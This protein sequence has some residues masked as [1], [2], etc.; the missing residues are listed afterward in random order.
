[1]VSKEDRMR[2]LAFAKYLIEMGSINAD[3]VLPYSATAL[4]NFH[5][6]LEFL[7][8]IILEDNGVYSK[9]YKEFSFMKMFNICNSK[10]KEKGLEKSSFGASLKKLKDRR[11][12]IKHK[13]SFPS[14]QDI[15]EAR[16][17]ALNLFKEFCLKFYELSYED[18]DL[19]DLLAD[20]RTKEC[21]LNI[22]DCTENI[23]VIDNL[24]LAFAYLLKDFESTKNIP[25][26]RSPYQLTKKRQLRASETGFDEIKPIKDYI[27]TTN[28]NIESLEEN[29]KII[30]F[31]IDYNKYAQFK[32]LV[33]VNIYWILS[34]DEPRRTL[35]YEPIELDNN[36]IEFCK[37]FIIESALKLQQFD[38]KIPEDFGLTTSLEVPPT[39]V[40]K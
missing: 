29:L 25:L 20:S 16:Y 22:K 9:S 32:F 24:A 38:F 6:A 35:R 14:P 3:N 2:C 4:L 13:G 33:P 28:D 7:F 26:S 17:T 5:D 37:N 11:V 12:D 40:I 39:K 18:I 19:V 31:G 36:Q 23:E 21:L 34:S 8:D 30:A 10:L 15:S 27:E 1:M